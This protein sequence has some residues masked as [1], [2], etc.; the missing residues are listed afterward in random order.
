M[1]RFMYDIDSAAQ[2]RVIE[3]LPERIRQALMEKNVIVAGG[4]PRDVY[5]GV[6]PGDID[7]YGPEWPFGEE[8]VGWVG[9]GGVVNFT[10]VVPGTV[11]QW[12][13]TPADESPTDWIRRN[14]DVGLCKIVVARRTHKAEL[15][16]QAIGAW[17]TLANDRLITI[18]AI[19]PSGSFRVAKHI[20]K[21]LRKGYRL[22]ED[23][24]A[25]IIT[26]FERMIIDVGAMEDGEKLWDMIGDITTRLNNELYPPSQMAIQPS[27]ITRR[28]VMQELSERT[29]QYEGDRPVELALDDP[30]PASISPSGV[31]Q[32]VPVGS[33][34]QERTT[35]APSI[36]SSGGAVSNLDN[37]QAGSAGVATNESGRRRYF[38][39]PLNGESGP[40]EINRN[41]Y[42]FLRDTATLGS[43]WRETNDTSYPY[44]LWTEPQAQ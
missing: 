25:S 5:C 12:I 44:R 41:T 43:I 23:N 31:E 13:R 42:E 36:P 24:V 1:S 33:G 28:D 20:A 14:F 32:S 26:L 39:S 10:S 17:E 27:R 22:S 18:I 19:H 6:Q 30:A 15:S 37:G 38:R 29:V 9:E 35:A 21:L 7:M 34:E 16:V 4:W 40:A 3:A 11:V 8:E 2:A